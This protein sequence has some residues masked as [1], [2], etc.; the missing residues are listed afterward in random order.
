MQ[1]RRKG[2]TQEQAAAKANL[3][4]RKTVGRYEKLGKLPTQLREPRRYRTRSDPFG[5]HWPEVEEIL[6]R[7]PEVEAKALFEWLCDKHPGEFQPGQ[8]RTFQRRVTQWRARH[9]TR[10]LSLP[11]VHL[12]GEVLE[13]DGTSMNA[14]GI[15]I[16][17]QPFPHLLIHSV[18]PYSNWESARVTQ[19]ESLMAIQLGLQSAA[20]RLGHVPR[21][22]RTDNTTAA[23]HELKPGAEGPRS[24]S[25]R[26]YSENYL[27]LLGRLG[28]E[29][30][31]THLSSPQENGD[32]EAAHRTLKSALHEHLLLR[33]HRD[34]A[35]Q[36]AYEAFIDSVIERRNALR[37]TRLAEEIAAMNPLNTRL[38]PA[39]RELRP[40]VSGAGMI[41]IL[42]NTY[43]VTSGL[44]G[45]RVVARVYEWYIEIWFGDHRLDVVPRLVGR[46]RH[47]VNYRHV[48]H[49]LLRKP[50]GFRAY[51]YREDLFPTRVFREAWDSC[52]ARM[53][54]RKADLTYLR[55]LKLAAAGFETDVAAVLEALLAGGEAW[56]DETVGR[57]VK[58]PAGVILGPRTQSVDPSD[59]DRLL[60]GVA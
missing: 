33:G 57:L 49:S 58:P 34:F 39:M 54:P 15:T 37:Q 44:K 1:E 32:I 45:K 26:G 42:D 13:T 43:S 18:L 48:I 53:T 55:I 47:R 19:S 60:A 30:Q 3:K 22:H 52:C 56:D 38:L 11:Q 35:N 8:V 28:M 5:V 23:T 6:G 50:G 24:I 29:P 41:R 10:L 46:G 16:A 14:L 9:T 12:P 27:A 21:F 25:G 40:R 7:A 4:S 36:S 17:G 31:T 2:R 20:Q 51:R 59:Y